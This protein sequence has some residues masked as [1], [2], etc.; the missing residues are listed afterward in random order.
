M[1]T[2]TKNRFVSRKKII[3]F[4]SSLLVIFGVFAYFKVTTFKNSVKELFRMNKER[5]EQNYYMAE[6]EFKML[7]IAY[8]LD[9]GNYSKSIQLIDTLHHQLKTGE[10]LVKI[11][12][13]KNKEEELEFYLNLQNPKTGAFMDDAY[14]LSTYHG[15]TENVLLH[16]EALTKE[17][18]IP[19][20]L[21]YPLRYLDHI[22]TQQKLLA[23]L[24]DV[25]IIGFLVSKFPQ[26]SFHNARDILS[27]A[28]DSELYDEKHGD[29]IIQKYNLYQFTPEWRYTLLKWFYEAQDPK[30]GLWG[31]KDKEGN[32][33]KKDMSNTSSILKAFV[34]KK[35]NNIHEEFPLRYKNELFESVLKELAKG[36][37]KDEDLDEAH[38]WN[39]KTPKGIRL[40]TRYLW[41]DTTEENRKKAQASIKNYIRVK[42]EKYYI[43]QEG[44]FSYYPNGKH[45]TLDGV[46]GY[47]IFREIGTLSSSKQ[48]YLWGEPEE[49]IADLGTIQKSKLTN[50]DFEK[51]NNLK[52]INSL[53][54]YQVTPNNNNLL[55][56]VWAVAYPKETAVLDILDLNQN[57][58][59]WIQT[60]ELTMGNWNSR[61]EI[62][63]TLHQLN[64][65]PFTVFKKSMPIKDVNHAFDKNN[66]LVVIGFDIMQVPRVKIS[67][68]KN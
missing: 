25:S 23:Y 56:K 54:I 11:P 22:N 55:S 46:G 6:F 13:F 15:P 30:T 3:I 43:P 1:A 38:E 29:L 64:P 24:N 59:Q 68:K 34:D 14:P 5:Q 35:G 4:I 48:A 57:M 41:K 36:E 20:K 52:D 51:F 32:L 7:G 8:H 45:A 50:S 49:T 39:L 67:F 28:R 26:T 47:S 65:K 27:L 21:K 63:N 62:Y 17:L 19:F 31:P 9:K 61:S 18:G 37:P 40:L 44:A 58:K 16:I 60:T 33:L 66:H 10:G 53:R 42:F 2:R 12:K